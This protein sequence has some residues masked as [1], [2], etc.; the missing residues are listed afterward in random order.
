MIRHDAPCDQ[1]KRAVIELVQR[2][3]NNLRNAAIPQVA[4]AAATI[5]SPFDF[6]PICGILRF[7]RVEPFEKAGGQAVREPERDEVK[8]LLEIPVWKIPAVAYS[9][10][11]RESGKFHARH[12]EALYA[13]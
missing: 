12:D 7:S 5:E 1:E 13:Q 2:I 9:N 4:L 8:A 6:T 11:T 10:T 3:D